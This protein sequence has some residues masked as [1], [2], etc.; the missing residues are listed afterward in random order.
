MVLFG[1]TLLVISNIIVLIL[2]T[3]ISMLAY[4]SYQKHKERL[5]LEVCIGFIFIT[6]GSLIEGILYEFL[7]VTIAIDHIVESFL[8]LVGLTII[9]K[10]MLFG[11]QEN[12]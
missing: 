9:G 10:S 1:Y 2:G 12:D 11:R 7:S 8:I 6:I 5:M 3:T 4:N